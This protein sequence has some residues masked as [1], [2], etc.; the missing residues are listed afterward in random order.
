MLRI[1]RVYE[2]ATPGDGARVLVDRLWP[3]G[4][5][6]EEA[7]L[8]DWLRDLA[9][10]DELRKWFGHDPRRFAEFQKRYEHEL[11]DDAARTL[12]DD[13]AR[14]ATRGTLTLVFAAKDAEHN[15]AVVLAR[16]IE[17][18]VRRIA[19]AASRRKASAPKAKATTS[20]RPPA[21]SPAGARAGRRASTG[22][23]RAR[24]PA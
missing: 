20:A 5:N 7:H 17:R 16:E 15:N 10:S 9:P 24:T 13:L 12:L 18:R 6:K 8:D 21:R 2:P 14:R 4:L 23:R 3:R 1:K 11:E 22:G 19:A